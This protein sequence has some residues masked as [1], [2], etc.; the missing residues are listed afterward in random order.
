VFHIQSQSNGDTYSVGFPNDLLLLNKT[1]GSSA[2]TYVGS[3]LTGDDKYL[4]TSSTAAEGT[5]SGLWSFDLQ[6]SFDQGASSASPWVGYHWKRAPNYFDVVAYT[7]DGSSGSYA[8][9]LGVVPELKI[10]KNRSGQFW[11][12]GGSVVTGGTATGYLVLNASDAKVVTVGED[13]WGSVDSAT[14]FS[15]RPAN[16]A[17]NLSGADYI[18]YLFASLPGIS[19]V[20]SVSH[21]S[22]SATN[23]DCGF[24]AGARFILLKVTDSGGNWFFYDTARGIVAGADARLKLN[25]NA[26]ENTSDDI[27]PLSSGF[28]ITSTVSTGNYIFY[29]IA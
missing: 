20:G 29:A 3:R 28:T 23:V 9:N 14:T 4:V 7:G 6:D 21:T 12:V 15:V 22:G 19:K 25:S 16:G 26:A 2:N 17:S 8:H 24:T 5:S 27:D 18:A 11:V 1:N 10:I 13:Y